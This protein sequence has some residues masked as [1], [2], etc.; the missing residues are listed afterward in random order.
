VIDGI[1]RLLGRPRKPAEEFANA[2]LAGTR[3][4]GV[5]VGG[6]FG[7]P[8]HWRTFHGSVFFYAF[9]PHDESYEK[10]VEHYARSDRPELYKVLPIALS[11]TG[12]KRTFYRTNEPTGSSILR[13][14]K[15]DGGEYVLESY[16]FPCRELSID[17]RT[18]QDVLD[19]M[20]EPIV[21]LIKLDIQG[22][23]L[24]VLGGLGKARLNRL[25][26]AELEVGLHQAYEG[27]ADFGKVDEFLRAHGLECFDVRVARTWRP[28]QGQVD[29]YQREVFDVHL[30]SPTISARAWEFDVVYFRGKNAVL[31]AGDPAT[32]RKLIVA[33]CGY[34]FFSEACHLVEKARERALFSQEEADRLFALIV[35]WHRSL[36]RRFY[37]APRSAYE[38]LR[39]FLVR[40][41]WG[42][43]A[44]WAQYLWTEYPNA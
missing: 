6:A 12:G 10:L 13:P 29:G 23:E 15:T 31:A 40:R 24:E 43:G 26:L 35:G 7:L 21:D 32:V 3:T 28:R 33:Y 44:R 19:E 5:D 8:P 22:A 27:Q 18:L 4:V 42:Q 37:H 34:N 20:R 14:K 9:E 17:T 2:I 25:L 38:A 30:N 39:R 1:R 36:H 41:H 16:F 11:G